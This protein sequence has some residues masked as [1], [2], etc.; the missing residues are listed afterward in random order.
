MLSVDDY[1]KIRR[2]FRDGMTIRELARTFHHSRRKIRQVLGQ[3]QP[4][5]YT[6]RHPPRSRTGSFS[7]LHRRRP[8]CR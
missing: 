8:C 1:G 3:P 2:A 6:R 7:R 5:P 4:K